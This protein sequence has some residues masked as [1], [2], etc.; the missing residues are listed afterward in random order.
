MERPK[1]SISEWL[2]IF[3]L[4]KKKKLTISIEADEG[5]LGRIG[6]LA[7]GIG[8]FQSDG[9]VDPMFRLPDGRTQDQIVH[10]PFPTLIVDA[11]I[12]LFGTEVQVGQEVA[13]RSLYFERGGM[14]PQVGV[15]VLRSGSGGFTKRGGIQ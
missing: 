3:F 7:V 4:G 11:K 9:M 13:F 5:H 14:T 1:K 12:G 6:H 2:E 10:A 15:D 8:S